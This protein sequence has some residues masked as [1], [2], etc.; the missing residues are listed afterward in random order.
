MHRAVILIIFFVLAV[1]VP[2][3]SNNP[4]RRYDVR[5]GLNDNSVKDICQDHRGYIW[6]ATKDGFCRFNGYRF[7]TFASS[8]SG[9]NLNVDAICPH[10]DGN[11][12]WAG[13]T[14]RL[15]LFDPSTSEL[16]P[17]SAR[18]DDGQKIQCC[19]CLGYD[20]MGDLWIGTDNGIFSWNEDREELR[21][22]SLGKGARYVKALL[23][24]DDGNIWAGSDAGLYLYDRLTDRFRSATEREGQY[25]AGPDG[26]DITAITQIGDNRLAVGTQ[27][28]R[29]L[30]F[31]IIKKQFTDISAGR[32]GRN[33]LSVSRIHTIFKKT[34]NQLLIGSDSGMY[35]LDL[36]NNV[37]GETTDILSKESIYKFFLDREGGLWIGTYF[38]GVNY[39]SPRQN[40][41][42]WFYDDG[43]EES[44]N[45][46][47]VSEFCEDRDGRIWIAT[48]NG[49]LNL[50]DPVTGK[51]ADFSDRS[52]NNIH[53]LEIVGETLLIGTF[54]YGLD[55]MDL[56]TGKVTRYQ[57][58]PG[59]STS[60]CNNYVYAIHKASSGTIYV[61]TMSGL[62]TF[63]PDT[64]K[65]SKIDRFNNKFIYD[66]NEDPEGNIWVA[67]KTDGIYV[68]FRDSKQWQHFTHDHDDP[69]SPMTDRFIRIYIDSAGDVWFCSEGAGICRYVGDGRFENYGCDEGLPAGIY[70]GILDDGVGNLWLSS[71]N[72]IIKYNP[73]L[74][75]Y[76]RYTAEDG[77]QSNLFN[78]RSSYMASDGTFYFGGINGFNC[79]SPFNISVNK[80]KPD[81]IISSV[82]VRW[83]DRNGLSTYKDHIPTNETMKVS[84]KV[85]SISINYECLSYVAPGQN[86]Y[87]WKLDG[88]N[89]E[90][91]ET[92]QNSV[93][94]MKLPA[95]RYT[96]MLKGC[97]NNGYWSDSV[98]TLDIKVLPSPF[99]SIWAKAGYIIICLGLVY[100]LIKYLL[101]RQEE[102]RDRELYKAKLDFFTQIAHEIKTPVTLIKSPLEQIIEAGKWD[103]SVEDNL[104]LIQKNANR[105]LDLI[106]QLLDF[107]KI[108]SDGYRLKYSSTDVTAIIRDTV[109]RFEGTVRRKGNADRDGHVFITI[110]YICPEKHIRINADSEALTKILSNLLSNALKYARSEITVSL[111]DIHDRT[112]RYISIEVKDDGPGIP[113]EIREKVFEPF[114]QGAA[115]SGNGFG[116]GLSLVKLLAERHGGRV[117]IHENP[118]GGC[119]VTVTI[120]DTE[121]PDSAGG[122]ET[123][124][125]DNPEEENIGRPDTDTIMIVEDTEDMREFLVRNFEDTY[126]VVA[127]ADG[128][129][130]MKILERKSCDLII[131]D[132]LMPEMNGFEFLAKVREDRI[133]NHIPFILLSA[134]DTSD[135]KIQGLESGADAYIEKPFSLNYLKATVKSLLDNRKRIF[136]HFASSPDI[137]Y[138]AEAISANDEKWLESV[139]S[140]LEENLTN[141]E[142]TIDILAEQLKT[143]RSNMQ[144]KI[145]GLTG[146][147]PSEYIRIFRL[148]TAA[149][150]LKEGYRVNEVCSLT[151]FDNW[152]YF[153]K[154]FKQQFGFSPK[155]FL[156]Q[157][158][159]TKEK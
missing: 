154:R 129:E 115:Y 135:T 34:G 123:G 101:I 73:G 159:E 21:H 63:D 110:S 97:N 54:S 78:F 12:I 130:A 58:I 102:K 3:Y 89:D 136:E 141:K 61:G 23:I 14:D 13:C 142:F 104:N 118:S 7:D 153:S 31:D 56:R 29:F 71:N 77:L 145:K 9:V 18:S 10:S 105:L 41:I 55:C 43:T 66:I 114:F 109:S 76:T 107:R 52:C 11:R 6:L 125:C 152:S 93:S 132:I 111:A 37:W 50:F 72:G 99:M 120:P 90:W 28:G 96:F 57:N 86:R 147:A 113:S 146:V 81:I 148:K 108:E 83:T 88:L 45:G 137:Q 17:L 33:P 59:D 94:F 22:Y 2:G 155:E 44:L 5:S 47:A 157:D 156:G 51:V 38:C 112:G 128:S 25:T 144:R 117:S 16:L 126:N 116:I 79:F 131:S 100:M 42:L 149:R 62:C 49:G 46:N 4:Y 39:L 35:T 134:I 140:I 36:N 98:E 53:A 119:T 84:S 138:D 143:S 158:K 68:R 64:G 95:G 26:L 48:E 91:I 87:A 20:V 27:D 32:S 15:M 80:I 70:F 75:S 8:R 24:D 40:E 82:R 127:A 67:G 106:H 122:E 121:L 85:I 150:L 133:L 151:G 60:I 19:L 74:H 30:A 92:D 69:G 139:N 1:Q 65:F 124:G 103:R